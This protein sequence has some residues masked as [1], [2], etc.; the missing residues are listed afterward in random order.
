MTN[1]ANTTPLQQ[2]FTTL[3][4]SVQVLEKKTAKIFEKMAKAAYTPELTKCLSPIST[5]I[6]KH[7]ERINLIIKSCRIQLP[8]VNKPMVTN[9]RLGKP[10]AEQDLKIIAE[11]LKFQHLKLAYYE[12]LHPVAAAEGMNIEATLIEQ[13][14]SDQRNTNTWLRQIVQ[15]ILAPVLQEN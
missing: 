2:Q 11:A 10:T 5:D 4:S 14:I 7:I 15:N 1:S 8:K 9:E 12:F 3:L 6:E 13:T